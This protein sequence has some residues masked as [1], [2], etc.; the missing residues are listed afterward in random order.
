MSGWRP[1]ESAPKNGERIVCWAPGWDDWYVLAW[2]HNPRTTLDYFG[3]PIEDDDYDRP[4]Q[5]PT[6]WHPLAKLPG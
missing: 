1:I 2:K 6:H 4:D 3:D 5:Q